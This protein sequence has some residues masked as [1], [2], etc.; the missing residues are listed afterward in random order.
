[1]ILLPAR[2]KFEFRAVV[3]IRASIAPRKSAMVE[4]QEFLLVFP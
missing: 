2:A 1:M 3:L 4:R